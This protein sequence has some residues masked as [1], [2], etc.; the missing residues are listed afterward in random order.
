MPEVAIMCSVFKKL[1]SSKISRGQQLRE[2]VVGN[3]SNMLKLSAILV[4]GPFVTFYVIHHIRSSLSHS[5]R[6]KTN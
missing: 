5:V 1:Y 2:L 3:F 4:L 6:Y